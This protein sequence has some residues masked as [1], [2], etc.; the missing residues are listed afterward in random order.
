MPTIN[1]RLKI[2]KWK[3]VAIRKKIAPGAIKQPLLTLGTSATSELCHVYL[4]AIFL[5]YPMPRCQGF[6]LTISNYC[7]TSC[8]SSKISVISLEPARISI[9][10]SICAECARVHSIEQR[11]I[12][13]C[14]STADPAGE[15]RKTIGRKVKPAGRLATN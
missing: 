4:A 3:L 5:F 11:R 2:S 15:K 14:T 12:D 1:R 13:T 9:H 10:P 8:T 7:Q 6:Q